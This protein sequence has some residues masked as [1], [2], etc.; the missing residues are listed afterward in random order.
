VRR[1]VL[2]LLVLG[3]S[4]AAVVALTWPLAANLGTDLPAPSNVHIDQHYAGWALAW[5]TH[6]LLTAPTQFAGANVYW[7]EP[8]ALFYGTPAFALLPAFAPIYLATGDVTTSLNLTVILSFALTAAALHWATV[9]F[10]GSTIAGIAA[11]GTYLTSRAVGWAELA[12]QYA[13]LA[14][15]PL[16]AVL[17]ADV[18]RTRRRTLLLAAL[19]AFQ[20]V[21]DAVYVAPVFLFV[22]ALAALVLGW[23]A[24]GRQGWRGVATALGVAAMALVPVYVEYALVAA[25]NPALREQ[26]V[27]STSPFTHLG[28]WLPATGPLA[29]GPIPFVPIAV[30]LALRLFDRERSASEGRAWVIA[31]TWFVATLALS[32]TIPFHARDLRAFVEAHVVRDLTRLGIAGVIGVSLLA[33]LGFA[34]TTRALDRFGAPARALVATGLLVAYLALLVQGMPWAIGAHPLVPA[35]VAGAE[36]AELR[37][38]RGPVVEIPIGREG[39]EQSLH[40]IAMY[41]STTHWRPLV[42]GYMSYYPAGFKEREALARRLPDPQALAA[43][44]ALGVATVVVRANGY[45][46]LV[47]GPWERALAQGRLGAVRIRWQDEAALVIDLLPTG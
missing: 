46:R 27:W 42:N 29:L 40:A 16:V 13:A 7:P 17:L 31:A 12:P 15:M 5:Q 18:P 34:A 20:G 21:A 3:T 33:G 36:S 44:R 47:F 35:P 41:R 28:K 24:E 26:T 8:R 11:A 22:T 45:P 30:G 43:L 25:A 38:G 9:R 23:S 6:A 19:L 1:F 39:V 4:V 37:A 32:W 2:L 14:A 10:T